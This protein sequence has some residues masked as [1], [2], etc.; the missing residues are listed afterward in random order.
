MNASSPWRPTMTDPSADTA[1]AYELPGSPGIPG[2]AD[3]TPS[4]QRVARKLPVAIM[5]EW[6]TMTDPSAEV[7]RTSAPR[8]P[9]RSGSCWSPSA[10]VQRKPGDPCALRWS[11]TTTVPSAETALAMLLSQG[12]TDPSTTRPSSSDHRYAL[13]EVSTCP[14]TTAPSAEVPRP[15]IVPAIA[16]IPPASVH[17]Y[18]SVTAI[19]PAWPMITRPSPEASYALLKG[20]AGTPA[21]ASIPVAAVHRKGVRPTA[22]SLCPTTTVPSPETALAT[23]C[24]VPPGRSPSPAKDCAWGAGTAARATRRAGRAKR[25]IAG[26]RCGVDM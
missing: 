25:V 11:P 3:G 4:T 17:R 18:A 13:V 15:E 21:S 14:T 23:L 7:P 10:A 1:S 9:S 20:P 22:D 6:P 19:S 26:K 24:V 5:D 8:E 2:S 16:C 12:G